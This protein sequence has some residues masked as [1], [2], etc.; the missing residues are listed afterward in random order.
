M[1]NDEW[2]IYVIYIYI[3]NSFYNSTVN[4]VYK[5]IYIKLVY[6]EN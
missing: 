5:P 4:G 1:G 2:N 3:Y 6:M